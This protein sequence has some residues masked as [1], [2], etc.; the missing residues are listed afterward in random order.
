MSLSE[1]KLFE[2]ILDL[3][4][5]VGLFRKYEF[6]RILLNTVTL[7]TNTCISKSTLISVIDLS[8]FDENWIR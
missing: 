3:N 2:L 8:S 4:H 5:V 7:D 6:P 1:I